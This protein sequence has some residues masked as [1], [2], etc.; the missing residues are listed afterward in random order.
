MLLL[1]LLPLPLPDF[2]THKRDNTN[3]N[4]ESAVMRTTATAGGDSNEDDGL[5]D[6]NVEEVGQ[7]VDKVT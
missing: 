1:L 7:Q 4:S 6:N 5:Q 3:G 2:R